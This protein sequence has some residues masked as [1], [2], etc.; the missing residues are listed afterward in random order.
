MLK[1]STQRTL[2]G[3]GLVATFGF[4]TGR[5]QGTADTKMSMEHAA[6]PATAS[7]L[8]V[9]LNNLFAEHLILAGDATGAALAGRSDEFKAA[10]GALDANSVALSQAVGSVYGHDAE[11]AFLALWRKHIGFTVDYVTGIA[12]KDKAKQDA[13]V[14]ALLGYSND[15]A[16]FLNAANPNLPV[17]VV[18]DLVKSHVVGLK[19]V[20]DNQAVMK[21][22]EAYAGVRSGAAHM[23][24][25]GDP[26]AG[27]I[28]KQYP[29]KFAGMPDAASA[30]LRTALNLTL[31]EHVYLAASA[32]EAALGGRS[33]EF[34]DAAGALD[35]NSV[36]LSQAIGSVYGPDAETAFL[37]LWRKHIGF[38]VDYTTAVAQKDK[39]G[40][41]KA[42]KDLIGYAS[43]FAAFLNSANP[44]L[45]TRVVT[46]LVK[47]HV[48]GL[49]AVVDAQATGDWTMA[50]AKLREA[51]AHM[52]MIADPL[53]DGISQQFP[54]KF[55]S[56]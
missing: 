40:Q 11:E 41:E 8:R 17:N 50:Y 56:R 14:N 35:A 31:R 49:K 30:S 32:T 2:I 46:D 55:A 54:E 47:S 1:Q 43:D 33:Q 28:V 6:I 7:D 12:S 13:A 10:A 25:I 48:V 3:L 29:G 24:M 44:N 51:A 52:Q 42:V 37:A 9:G 18:S 39:K 38:F 19:S 16:A 21:Y 26:L 45:P 23:Q 27:A 5:A 4:G 36:Q 20:I 22:A 53:A 15:L 34:T